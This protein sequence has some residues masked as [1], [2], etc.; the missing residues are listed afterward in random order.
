MK[1][2]LL[3]N[4]GFVTNVIVWD[5]HC[6]APDGTVA[7]VVE[8]DV[9]VAPGWTFANGKFIAPPEPPLESE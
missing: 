2:A 4:T 7:F 8:D 9:A 3:D 6:T 1:A 5:D